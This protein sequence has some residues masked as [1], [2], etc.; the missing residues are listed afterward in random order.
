MTRK[1]LVTVEMI[2]SQTPPRKALRRPSATAIKVAMA[3]AAKPTISDVLVPS[4]SCASTSW[5]VS[6]VPSQC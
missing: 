2:S 3:E 6:V 5:P 4:T 1:A